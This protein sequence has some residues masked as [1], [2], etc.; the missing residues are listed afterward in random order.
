MH[1]TDEQI[2][3]Q[4]LGDEDAGA[5]A[6]FAVCAYCREEFEAYRD[7]LTTVRDNLPSPPAGYAERLWAAIEPRL[8]PR[9][10]PRRRLTLLATAATVAVVCIAGLFA[11]R[12]T[13]TPNPP[14]LEAHTPRHR[15]PDVPAAADEQRILASKD[16]EGLTA[17]AR[18][19]KSR[20]VRIHAIRILGL[21]GSPT[22]SATLV[23]LYGNELDPDVR[24]AIVRSLSI[25]RDVAEL[26]TLLKTEKSPAVQ[27]DIQTALL[28]MH[29]KAEYLTHGA[30]R[31]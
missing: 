15:P 13:Q 22:V 5:T 2:I 27:H 18:S 26:E 8:A 21:S 24:S 4:A 3:D 30:G 9:R 11:W 7:T 6:H 28:G 23:A 29:P 14:K 20:K 25:R 12:Y 1:L 31:Q 16:P 17:L 10:P 19:S